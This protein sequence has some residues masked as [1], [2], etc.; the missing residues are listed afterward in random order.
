MEDIKPDI[1]RF[2][3]FFKHEKKLSGNHIEE[4]IEEI[5]QILIS[6]KYLDFIN[7]IYDYYN[8]RIMPINKCKM[9][10]L[11]QCYTDADNA[12]E[13]FWDLLLGKDLNN[14]YK[15]LLKIKLKF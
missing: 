5:N 13:H 6:H 3:D 2:I 8:S 10:L 7:Y 9:R 1:V 14:E 11:P 4:C 15:S 12:I